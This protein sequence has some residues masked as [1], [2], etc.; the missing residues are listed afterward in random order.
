MGIEAPSPSTESPSGSTHGAGFS[1]KVVSS[2][3][4]AAKSA[5]S[6][7]SLPFLST[8]DESDSSG[9]D[10]DSPGSATHSALPFTGT[11]HQ[12]L[13][14]LHNTKDLYAS[15]ALANTHPAMLSK[16]SSEGLRAVY[17]PSNG[18][19]ARRRPSFGNRAKVTSTSPP[20]ESIFELLHAHAKASAS[21]SSRHSGIHNS[22]VQTPGLSPKRANNGLNSA[23]TDNRAPISDCSTG[24]PRAR[25]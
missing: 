3:L 22:S 2:T 8:R 23:A 7:I 15:H 14:T 19:K 10:L 1:T 12:S 4:N 5:V 25:R 11:T 9:V 16:R 20:E 24:S 18:T 21:R 13:V 17:A 6:F